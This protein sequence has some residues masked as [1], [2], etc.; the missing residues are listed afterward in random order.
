MNTIKFFI[1]LLITI[2]PLSA[3]DGIDYL[4]LHRL[5]YILE[6]KDTKNEV[7]RAFYIKS[8]IG[9]VNLLEG[10]FWLKSPTGDKVFIEAKNLAKIDQNL[11]NKEDQEKI[12][13]GFVLKLWI[14][15]D[16]KKYANYSLNHDFEKDSIILSFIKIIDKLIIVPR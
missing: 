4:N 1:F 15:D 10:N 6:K 2:L 11:L 8:E 9:K 14:P 5:M 7:F 3:K 13:D 16:I 12:K